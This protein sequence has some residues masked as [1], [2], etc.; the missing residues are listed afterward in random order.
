MYESK[1]RVLKR[2]QRNPAFKYSMQRAELF[3]IAENLASALYK[4]LPKKERLH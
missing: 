4:Q 1:A 2:V 3:G